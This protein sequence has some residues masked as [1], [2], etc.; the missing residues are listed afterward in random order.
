MSEPLVVRAEDLRVGD[1]QS[2][3]R[4]VVT[5]PPVH[6]GDKVRVTWLLDAGQYDDLGGPDGDRTEVTYALTSRVSLS[7]R[8]PA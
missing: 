5:E 6:S 4:S 8:G 7:S 1:V 3:T 2:G